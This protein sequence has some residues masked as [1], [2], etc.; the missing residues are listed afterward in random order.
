[1]G[2]IVLGL[3]TGL[4]NTGWCVASMGA[5][6]LTVI[7]MGVISSESN[8][9][10][11]NI[12]AGDDDWAR[13]IAI[14][15]ELLRV[16]GKHHPKAITCEAISHVRNSAAMAK[17]GRVFGIGAALSAFYD[18]PTLHATPRDIKLGV[19]KNLKADKLEIA[20]ALD[21]LFAGRPRQLLEELGVKRSS[22]NDNNIG[23]QEHGYDALASIVV[24]LDHDLMRALRQGVAC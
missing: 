18:L 1:M 7:E 22:K 8:A 17:I 16:V 11:Q 12:R 3:D 15:K 20:N 14:C 24:N 21:Q 6:T 2:V 23:R 5:S 9:K 19:C 10:K 13:S 4:A